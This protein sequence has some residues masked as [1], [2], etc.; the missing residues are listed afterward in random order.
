MSPNTHLNS[1][2]L[3]RHTNIDTYRNKKLNRE[4]E[5]YCQQH[6]AFLRAPG[7]ECDSENNCREMDNMHK[8]S[9]EPPSGR[10]S[11]GKL[12]PN[13]SSNPFSSLPPP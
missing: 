10:K 7:K 8:T 5:F 12:T 13:S 3:A 9:S 6:G 4:T 1:I 2:H 11:L